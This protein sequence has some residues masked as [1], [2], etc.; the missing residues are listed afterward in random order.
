MSDDLKIA[1]WEI[2]VIEP[3]APK[4]KHGL[5]NCHRCGQRDTD[6]RHKTVNGKGKVGRIPVD[7]NR[8]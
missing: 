2:E 7:K 1:A 3:E 8:G 4:C 5:H 6:H